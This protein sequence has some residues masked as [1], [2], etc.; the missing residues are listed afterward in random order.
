M[1][2]LRETTS[3][4]LHPSLK[5]YGGK[6]VSPQSTNEWEKEDQSSIQGDNDGTK[7]FNYITKSQFEQYNE[8]KEMR[9]LNYGN[10]IASVFFLIGTILFF[11]PNKK[12]LYRIGVTLNALG[13]T[14][15]LYAAGVHYKDI[16]HTNNSPSLSDTS[17]KH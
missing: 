16:H 8:R 7:D 5:L 15:F 1:Q 6:S 17:G 10:I 9:R 13:A 2:D 3:K 12:T 11:V 4:P 14:F